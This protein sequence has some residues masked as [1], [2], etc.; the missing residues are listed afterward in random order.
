[1]D[2][3]VAYLITGVGGREERPRDA[4]GEGGCLSGVAKVG[5]GGDGGDRNLFL[6]ETG[7]RVGHEGGDDDRLGHHV[8]DFGL[9]EQI[10]RGRDMFMN[11][12]MCN[13]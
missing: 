9:L 2:N 11:G 10:N 7:F 8:G 1:M 6:T 13:P 12:Y 5:E 4:T 3:R